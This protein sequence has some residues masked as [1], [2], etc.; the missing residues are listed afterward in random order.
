[1]ARRNNPVANFFDGFNSA[2]KAVKQ[3]AQD[4]ETAEA[5][6]AKQEQIVSHT[7]E[8]LKSIQDIVGAKDKEGNAYYSVQ[9]ADD[10]SVSITPNFKAEGTE[11]APINVDELK[12]RVVTKFL[13]KEYDQPLTATQERSARHQALSGIYAKY[14]DHAGSLRSEGIAKSLNDQADE[15]TVRS[16]ISKGISPSTGQQN[17]S[18]PPTGQNTAAAIASRGI[19][20]TESPKNQL[21]AYLQ[22][23]APKVM[24]T[25]VKQGR[26]D[27]AS[28]FSKF[29][30]T[31]Q[32]RTY[33]KEWSKGI[34]LLG[35]G[36]HK[37]A[38][39]VFENMY[40]RQMYD[41]GR[42]V[43][44]APSDGGKTYQM[45]VM[46]GDEVIGTRKLPT[47]ELTH[48]AA[49]ALAPEKYV[50]MQ[51]RQQYAAE[52]RENTRTSSGRTAAPTLTQQ[53]RNA[54]IDAAR[55]RIDGLSEDD[56]RRRTAK[57][58]DTGRENPDYDPSLSRA[59]SLAGRRKVG[60]DPVFDGSSGPATVSS[61]KPQTNPYE[62]TDVANRFRADKAMSGHS[63]GKD[64]P[65]GVEVIRDGK[66]IGYYY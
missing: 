1:M 13:G 50:Q 40:N 29:I 55:G 41:D 5:I 63:L 24:E 62:R 4:G 60:A 28:K 45:T 51:L 27:E 11:T 7:P 42:T 31:E 34:G 14:G 3:V 36:D 33:A 47:S 22:S 59:A 8:Q 38:L 12:G 65:R 39:G 48:M 64:T 21:D 57:T 30:E 6:N 20:L 66:V 26:I 37:A 49:S 52:R 19:G 32:G 61:S 25:M 53:A 2:Y 9:K 16:I 56:V 15:E 43:K 10:G 17:T 23:V 44:L 35:V 54:E 58:T 46:N 18:L